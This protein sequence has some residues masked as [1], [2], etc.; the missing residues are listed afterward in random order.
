M[1]TTRVLSHLTDVRLETK[2]QTKGPLDW[3][4]SS[5]NRIL[6]SESLP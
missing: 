2:T 3:M 5:I 6:S 4:L 1:S